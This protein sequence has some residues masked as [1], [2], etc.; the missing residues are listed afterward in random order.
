MNTACVSNTEDSFSVDV[1]R[2]YLP[3]TTISDICPKCQKRCEYDLGDHYL[4][5]PSANETISF[6]CYCDDCNFDW[7]VAIKLHIFLS[8]EDTNSKGNHG[9]GTS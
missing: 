9:N 1:K 3:G 4:S 7:S 5:Y 8:L 6:N 2:F